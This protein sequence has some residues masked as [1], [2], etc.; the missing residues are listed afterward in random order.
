MRKMFHLASFLHDLS[1][2]AAMGKTS[3]LSFSRT[4]IFLPRVKWKKRYPYLSTGVLPCRLDDPGRA[5]FSAMDVGCLAPL[6]PSPCYFLSGET[7]TFSVGFGPQ[8]EL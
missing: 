8:P 3:G 5:A 2:C 7:N 1:Y 6:S 4:L